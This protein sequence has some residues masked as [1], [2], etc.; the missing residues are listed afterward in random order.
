MTSV[1][2]HFSPSDVA[3]LLQLE[4]GEVFELI[5]TGELPAVRIAGKA[6]VPAGALEQLLEHRQEAQ[7]RASLWQQSQTASIADLFGQRH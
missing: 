2:R 4:V 6:R 7:R 5:D 3:E 1:E